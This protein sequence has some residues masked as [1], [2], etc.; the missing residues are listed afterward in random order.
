MGYFSF[1]VSGATYQ[2]KTMMETESGFFVAPENDACVLD[3]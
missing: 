3:A 2:L 1:T